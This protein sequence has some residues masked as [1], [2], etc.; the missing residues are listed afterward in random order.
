[1]I[2]I[3]IVANGILRPGTWSRVFRTTMKD[4]TSS[5]KRIW[6]FGIPFGEVQ[7]LTCIS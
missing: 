4:I 3:T 7:L 2:I 1:L 6:S 5:T